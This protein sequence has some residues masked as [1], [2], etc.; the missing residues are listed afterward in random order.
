MIFYELCIVERNTIQT[1]RSTHSQTLIFA[2]YI[3]HQFGRFGF[4]KPNHLDMITNTTFDQWQI[5][6]ANFIDEW[7]TLISGCNIYP[8]SV[9]GIRV[10][11]DKMLWV[12]S[13]LI[14][15]KLW[16]F[17][18]VG[19][20]SIEVVRWFFFSSSNKCM[21]ERV[22]SRCICSSNEITTK[23]Q[24]QD[25]TKLFFF[26]SL[27]VCVQLIAYQIYKCRNNVLKIKFF[28]PSLVF[29]AEKV[30]GTG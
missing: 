30:Y 14:W 22:R 26:L 17:H 18:V 12:N 25:G 23:E 20:Q 21:V 7:F 16:K 6:P 27:C 13:Q 10:H 11:H 8:W 24:R 5:V 28:S 4:N 15:V 29:R 3:W 2:H 1:V 19:R 9:F